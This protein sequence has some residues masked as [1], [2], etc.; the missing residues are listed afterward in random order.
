VIWMGGHNLMNPALATTRWPN[1]EAYFGDPVIWAGQILILGGVVLF[2]ERRL[3][4]IR[5]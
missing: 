4:K 5:Y 2:G 1:F 3:R